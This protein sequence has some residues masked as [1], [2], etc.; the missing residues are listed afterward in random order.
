M[1]LFQRTVPQG[2]S[3]LTTSHP[4]MKCAQGQWETY[5]WALRKG[6]RDT[7][8]QHK[9]G[10]GEGDTV[11]VKSCVVVKMHSGSNLFHRYFKL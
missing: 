5:N 2:A 9:S 8:Q 10:Q 6:S 11:S 7:G 4:L 1:L 3:L